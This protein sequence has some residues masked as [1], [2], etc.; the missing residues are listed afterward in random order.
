MLVIIDGSEMCTN[1]VVFILFQIHVL[2]VFK[3]L[4]SPLIHM[5]GYYENNVYSHGDVSVALK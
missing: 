1:K 3:R 5:L 4:S 2:K